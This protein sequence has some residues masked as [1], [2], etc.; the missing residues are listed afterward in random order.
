M[1]CP[2]CGIENPPDAE[3]CGN[4]GV[5][6]AI[7]PEEPEGIIYCTSCGTKNS[8]ASRN[9]SECGNELRHSPSKGGFPVG[10]SSGDLGQG[11]GAVQGDLDRLIAETFRI[12]RRSFRQFFFIALIAEVPLIVASLIPITAVAVIFALLGILLYI[13]A[14]AATIYGVAWSYLDRKITVSECYSRAWRKFWPLLIGWI[15]FAVA[16][17]LSGILVLILVGIILLFYILV[18]RFFYSQAIVLE[19]KMPLAALGRS[20]DLVKGNWW[21]VFVIGIIFVVGIFLISMILSVPGFLI[22]PF[23]PVLGALLLGIA[24]A[25]VAPIGYIGATVVYFH[26]RNGKETYTLE[27]MA[28]ELDR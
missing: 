1:N 14:D 9:C 7:Q 10:V 13:V 20:R 4:C 5:P 26:L 27:D 17:V 3:F 12:Y 19:G 11:M 24:A 6:L 15:V 2:T 18:S 16:L 21:R 28:V 22:E 8:T 25:V 23:V